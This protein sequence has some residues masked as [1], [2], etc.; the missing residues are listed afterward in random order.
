MHL[1]LI[2][3]HTPPTCIHIHPL[4][5]IFTRIIMPQVKYLRG[6]FWFVGNCFY[7]QLSP[8]GQIV[9][10][11]Y[12]AGMTKRSHEFVIKEEIKFVNISK[13]PKQAAVFINLRT[14]SELYKKQKVDI[15]KLHQIP[16]PT[17]SKSMN[18][19]TRIRRYGKNIGR[20]AF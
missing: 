19:K 18:L 8:W 9:H 16:I 2:C 17:H 14:C 3:I 15:Q 7:S 5:L 10:L 12:F 11:N 20:C 1:P 13:V 4:G 6:C